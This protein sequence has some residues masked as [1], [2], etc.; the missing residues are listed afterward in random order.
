M[1]KERERVFPWFSWRMEELVEADEGGFTLIEL[2]AV[3]LS[4]INSSA[5]RNCLKSPGSTRN[6]A[7]EATQRAPFGPFWPRNIGQIDARSIASTPFQT[8]S[9][10][11]SQKF[12]QEQSATYQLPAFNGPAR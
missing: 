9:K 5:W 8:V 10:G 1:R 4:S 2:L 11:S 3:V 12:A 6:L 7:L